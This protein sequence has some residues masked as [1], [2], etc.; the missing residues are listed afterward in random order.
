MAVENA[1][2]SNCHKAQRALLESQAIMLSSRS[3]HEESDV[4]QDEED[5]A[6]D[7]DKMKVKPYWYEC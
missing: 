7:E 6:N 3:L 2:E 1:N 4:D 5:E